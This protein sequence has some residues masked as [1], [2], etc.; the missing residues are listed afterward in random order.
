MSDYSRFLIRQYSNWGVYIH[1][2]QSYLGRCVVWCDREDAYDL[3]DATEGEREELF[4]I[5]HNLKKA[6]QHAFQCDWYNYSFLG[7]VTPH[8]HCHF[9]PRYKNERI[10]CDLAFQDERWGQNYRTDTDFSIPD[11]V[12]EKIRLKIKA[13]LKS[14]V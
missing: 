7:N 4:R 5:L 8:L 6:V 12:L 3:T 11:D 14:T 2:N 13:E 10:F 1:Q 9:I